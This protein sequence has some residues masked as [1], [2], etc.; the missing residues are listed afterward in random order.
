MLQNHGMPK[1]EA[2]NFRH[3]KISRQQVSQAKRT[4]GDD[5][6]IAFKAFRGLLPG[7]VPAW[8]RTA[9]CG[10]NGRTLRRYRRCFAY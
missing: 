4:V 5:V 9:A 8:Y 6:F 7:P 3:G 2:D 10:F 1:Y